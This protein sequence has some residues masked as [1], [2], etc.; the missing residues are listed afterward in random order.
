MS[1]SSEHTEWHDQP[2]NPQPTREPAADDRVS[3]G[4]VR[5]LTPRTAFWAMFGL[6]FV[7]SGLWALSSPPMSSPDEP[8]H[9]IK[10]AAV[11]RGQLSGDETGQPG[12]SGAVRVPELFSQLAG[13]PCYA[14]LPEVT[15]LCQPALT[16]D[17]AAESTAVT[18]AVRYNPLYY[19]FAGLPSLFTHSPATIYLMRLVG[20]LLASW[21]LALAVR[22]LAELGRSY[23][24]MAAFLVSVPPMTVF[25]MGSINPQSVELSGAV[26]VWITL[27]ALLRSPHEPTLIRRLF[28]LTLGVLF[29]ANVRGLGP[30]I[31]AVIVAACLAFAPWQNLM[32]LIRNRRTWPYAAACA[33]SIAGGL[34]WTKLAGTLSTS[35][36]VAFPPWA[37]SHTIIR[38]TVASTN[39]Y[40]RESIGWFGWRDT[41][42]PVWTYLF[43]AALVLFVVIAGFAL[44]RWRERIVMLILAVVVLVLPIY[45]EFEQARFIG[46]FWQ[47]RYGL[48]LAVG[49][50]LL[51][52]FILQGVGRQLPDWI[53]RRILLTL[54][55][56]VAFLQVNAL[57]VNVRRYVNGAN[58]FAGWVTYDKDAWL[59][60]VNPYLLIA[61]C[62]LAWLAVALVAVPSANGATQAYME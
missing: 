51:A 13:L 1:R 53:G 40:L 43:G 27:L 6:M 30:L 19:A 49:G 48:P 9:A 24:Q 56:A 31:L 50:P 10:A 61:L 58:E 8:A 7:I 59:P 46:L 12:G 20:A 26:L 14:G 3:S 35:T 42:M 38:K 18:S 54:A 16:G 23:W 57:V 32:A 55:V 15:A 52:G 17:L 22:T 28:R 29:V 11:V 21:M 44:G 41:E 60:P 62:T 2:V 4:L 39:N 36:A 34:L 45:A 25:L 37:D 47:G 33:V 5:A